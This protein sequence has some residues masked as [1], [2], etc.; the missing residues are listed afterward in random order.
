MVF[1]P[2]NCHEK[3]CERLGF[4]L[5]DSTC[6]YRRRPAGLKLLSVLDGLRQD[7]RPGSVLAQELEAFDDQREQ[8]AAE[9]SVSGGVDL[10][11]PLD[12]FYSIYDTVRP[13]W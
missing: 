10:S 8:D 4:E 6:K 9:L 5:A 13:C 12:V 1:T 2:P 7:A 3:C 11:S